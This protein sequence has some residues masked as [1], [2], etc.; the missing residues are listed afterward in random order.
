MK[1]LSYKKKIDLTYENIDNIWCLYP[2]SL[3]LI[4]K[5]IEKERQMLANKDETYSHSQFFKYGK[6]K[7]YFED[8]SPGEIS[9]FLDS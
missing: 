1:E 7:K 5:S 4:E 8:M 6:P 2:N 9:E 3:R